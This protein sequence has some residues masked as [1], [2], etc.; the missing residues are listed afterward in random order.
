MNSK[1]YSDLDLQLLLLLYLLIF[2]SKL[3]RCAD[4]AETNTL[5]K[6]ELIFWKQGTENEHQQAH[7]QVNIGK[8]H[9]GITYA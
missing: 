6:W 7:L 9:L 3:C 8:Y 5:Q 4:T 1:L 2:I